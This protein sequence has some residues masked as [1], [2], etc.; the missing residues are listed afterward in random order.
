MEMLLYPEERWGGIMREIYSSDFE[1]AN[2]EFIE[3]WM[4]DPFA[5]MPDHKGGE[6]Y[7]NLGNISEDVLKDSR[8][9]F[10][11]GLPTSEV[12][13]KV[14]TTVW[15]RIPLTQSLVQGFSAGDET[16]KLPGCGSGRTLVK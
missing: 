6:L 14:D 12:V 7:F 9:T 16:R 1:Q 10:E 8:K 15:G 13:E 3:F 2:V 4:M 11:N 5:E